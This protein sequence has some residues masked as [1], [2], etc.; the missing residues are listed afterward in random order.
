MALGT[1]VHYLLSILVII[2]LWIAPVYSY[3]PL[4]F[5]IDLDALTT[6][7]PPNILL[8]EALKTVKEAAVP[9]NVDGVIAISLAEAV[10][11]A[12]GGFASR[13]V[14]DLIG[15]KKR[16]TAI[17]KITSTSAFFGARGLVRI[18]AS[19]VGLPRPLAIVLGSLLGSLTSDAAKYIGRNSKRKNQALVKSILESSS[20]E[21]DNV[22][23]PEVAGGLSKWVVYDLF[24]SYLSLGKDDSNFIILDTEYFL[25]GVLA[26]WCGDLV[27]ENLFR[28]NKASNK[29][30]NVTDQV[31]AIDI[32]QRYSR[33]GLEG[34]VL[35]LSYE[36]ILK[37]VK[38]IVPDQF[39]EKLMFSKAFELVEE[40]VLENS[41]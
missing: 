33:V 40:E 23:W 32:G 2:S 39:N 16:D 3:L 22:T 34:G 20:L 31:P 41:I 7:P 26:A 14:A 30:K 15:D 6:P 9:E 37:L 35:F 36:T 1:S 24:S 11:G 27:K 21:N 19:V 13:R 5:N 8:F 4:S 29:S 28:S 25:L 10:S 12:L 17:T 38:S 18:I